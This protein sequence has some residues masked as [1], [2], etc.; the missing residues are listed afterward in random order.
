MHCWPLC[1]S[2]FR[3]RSVPL[4]PVHR[5]L[6]HSPREQNQKACVRILHVLSLQW[7]PMAAGAPH[8]C[9]CCEVI[10]CWSCAC[11]VGSGIYSLSRQC[12]AVAAPPVLVRVWSAAGFDSVAITSRGGLPVLSV[13]CGGGHP[14]G[15]VHGHGPGLQLV[16]R[17]V[18]RGQCAE[19]TSLVVHALT[20]PP[21]P[22]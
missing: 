6:T 10:L 7:Y 2:W 9:C 16:R 5:P 20:H 14:H 3:C 18:C 11:R 17:R 8:Q 15:A 12:L 21:L 1:R 4:F 19:P 22:T 13:Y